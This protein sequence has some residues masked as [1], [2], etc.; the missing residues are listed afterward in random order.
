VGN[1]LIGGLIGTAVDF[2]SGGTRKLSQDSVHVTLAPLSAHDM[3]VAATPALM[4]AVAPVAAPVP[5]V[6]RTVTEPA[7]YNDTPAAD[8]Q[9]RNAEREFRAGKMSL[10]E[11]REIKKVLTRE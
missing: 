7:M 10:E 5:T 11:F 3:P 2:A 1:I 4:P 6:E 8:T 9:L